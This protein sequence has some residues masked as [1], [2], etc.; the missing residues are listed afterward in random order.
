MCASLSFY[1]LQGLRNRDNFSEEILEAFKYTFSQGK[2]CL[3]P[4]I[5]YIRNIFNGL[6]RRKGPSKPIDIPV[7][8]IWVSD[9]LH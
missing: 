7:L 3:T 6:A 4:P 1:Y 5:N 9:S 8:L 2:N